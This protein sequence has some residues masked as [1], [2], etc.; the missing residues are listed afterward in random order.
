[1]SDR[2]QC[3]LVGGGILRVKGKRA[4]K[5]QSRLRRPSCLHAC[6]GTRDRRTLRET[7]TQCVKDIVVIVVVVGWMVDENGRSACGDGFSERPRHVMIILASSSFPLI[8]TE[9]SI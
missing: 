9:Y 2:Y 5:V 4:S 7:V 1:M 3:Y 6:N 8:L